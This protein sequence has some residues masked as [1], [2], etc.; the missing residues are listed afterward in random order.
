MTV[1]L[2]TSRL[3]VEIG[4]C[5]VRAVLVVRGRVVRA[6]TVA[7][8]DQRSLADAITCALEATSR[9]RWPRPTIFAAIGPSA[10]Q[11]R[12]LVHL[13]PVQGRAAMRGLVESSSG[14][15]FL[16]NG[17]PL[18]ISDIR[19]ERG[20]GGWAA[21]LDE[22]PVR[23]LAE[24]CGRQRLRLAVVAPAV[25][26]AQ[27]VATTERLVLDD[28]GVVA[29][30]QLGD[31]GALRT[32]RRVM[33]A[34]ALGGDSIDEY[35]AALGATLI[36]RREPLALHRR[37]LRQW[38]AAPTTQWRLGFAMIALM[39]V[40]A[41][42][43]L[44]PVLHVHRLEAKARVKLAALNPTYRGARWTETD[45]SE[46]TAALSELDAF[47]RRRRSVVQLLGEL[48]QGLP[49]DIWL[50][51]LRLNELGG[52]AVALS[53][54]AA[55]SLAAFANLPS[56]TAPAIVGSVSSEIVGG[57]RVERVA[58]RFRWR[59]AIRTAPTVRAL[60]GGARR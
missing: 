26:A 45:L 32:V 60:A 30:A 33:S 50:Q 12:H 37:V 23:A 22:P 10:A 34:E 4:R 27:C 5:A 15:F 41:L 14:R 19:R 43:F 40:L 39:L 25:V 20:G 56:L 29:E 3:G 52:T 38:D 7:I 28:G 42:T 54:H 21:A 48:T 35:T 51:S 46:T 31:D 9:A 58:I 1:A 24:V 16:K 8:D 55:S 6:S 44:L 17:V 11:L 2:G 57:T 18:L 47:A 36:D 49:A 53:P 13:P 59:N